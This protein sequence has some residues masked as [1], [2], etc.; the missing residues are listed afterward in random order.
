M[1]PLGVSKLV[2]YIRLVPDWY[3]KQTVRNNETLKLVF[4]DN[5]DSYAGLGDLGASVF[6]KKGKEDHFTVTAYVKV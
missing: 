3:M 2:I 5:G 6:R 4:S 1:L